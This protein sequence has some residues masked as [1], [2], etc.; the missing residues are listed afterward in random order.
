MLLVLML[1]CPLAARASDAADWMTWRGPDMRG[2]SPDGNPPVTWSETENIQWKV[3]LTGDESNSSPIICCDKIFFQTAVETDK[4][5]EA[6]PE[7]PAADPNQGQAGSGRPRSQKPSAVYRF[8]MVCLDRLTGKQ[9]WE[10]TVCEVLP[11]EGHHGDHGFASFS[12]ITDG[13]LLWANFG[14]RGIYCLDL[15][16]NIKWSKDLGPL[17]IRAGF[18]EGGSAALAG[19]NLIVVRDHEGESSIIALNRQ[20]GEPAWKKTR[21]ERTSWTTP[22]VTQV[23]GK[24]QIIV[25][26]SN[27]T[28]C[29]DAASGDVIWECGGQTENIIPTPVLG[30]D[31]VFCTSGFRGAMLQAIQLGR[32]GDLTGTDAIAWQVT[33][34]TPYVPSPLLYGDKLYFCSG[35]NP[36]LS[37]YNA[38]TGIPYYV[39]QNLEQIKGI[40]ASPVGAADRVYCVGRNGVTYVLKNSDTFEVLAVNTLADRFDCSPA[41]VGDKLYLKGKQN[42][43]CIANQTKS[44]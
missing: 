16:G 29:Y 2:L 10:K 30:F 18:G 7:P 24:L 27:K 14:S 33:D 44:E 36:I 9:I 1:L 43:Y 34:A 11:H 37:C 38:Q 8:N 42:L 17:T 6:A 12:P 19:E 25:T 23:D 15:D 28:R 22:M 20:T 35:T 39:K 3:K 13:K 21:D 4:K 40:Y 5:V 31:R 32:T 41:I 26:G